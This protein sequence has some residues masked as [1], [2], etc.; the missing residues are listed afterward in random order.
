M[1]LYL[2]IIFVSAFIICL[3]NILFGL[4]LLNCQW[5]FVIVAV[6]VGIIFEFMLDLIIAII[7]KKSP[8]KWYGPEKRIFNVPTW[9]KRFAE[10]MGVKAWK[11]KIWELGSAGGFSK[12]KIENPKDV[13]YIST[14]LIEINKGIITHYIIKFRRFFY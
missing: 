8:N 3:F 10:S 7:I 12:R 11:D 4:S 9:Y 2:S 1:I 14:F 6:A 13:N 5:W